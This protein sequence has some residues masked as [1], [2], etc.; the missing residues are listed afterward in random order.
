MSRTFEVHSPLGDQ[1]Q[2]R[3]MTGHEQMGRLFEFRVRLLSASD[4]IQPESLLGQDMTVSA[5]LS[6]A[7]GVMV[8]RAIYPAR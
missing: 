1:L 7:G 2:F 6:N 4:S 8:V 3:G 5:D